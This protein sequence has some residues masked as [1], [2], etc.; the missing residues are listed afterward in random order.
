M[1]HAAR[2]N[3]RRLRGT[4]AEYRAKAE[5]RRTRQRKNVRHEDGLLMISCSDWGTDHGTVKTC[6]RLIIHVDGGSL[7]AARSVSAGPNIRPQVHHAHRR[8]RAGR[9]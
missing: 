6:A 2:E 9:C 4:M 8:Q 5:R 1:W 3:E 7:A